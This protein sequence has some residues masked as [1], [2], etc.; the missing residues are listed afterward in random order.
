[1]GY[2][3]L[4]QIEPRS[5]LGSFAKTSVVVIAATSSMVLCSCMAGDYG[6]KQ[7]PSIEQFCREV[8]LLSFS[9][10]RSNS[11]RVQK[12]CM[13]KYCPAV[14]RC[15]L[16]GKDNGRRLGYLGIVLKIGPRSESRELFG[17]LSWPTVLI[18]IRTVLLYFPCLPLC[19]I[20]VVLRVNSSMD[21]LGFQNS[22][23]ESDVGQ[24]R[25]TR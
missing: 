22:V 19:C 20:A 15:Q 9:K 8:S 23:S 13:F 25:R 17:R 2:A 11:R 24:I 21:V 4:T 6:L 14:S 1:M 7:M 12:R 3:K 16:S 5:W 18:G 10:M